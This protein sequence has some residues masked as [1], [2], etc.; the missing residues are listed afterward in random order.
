MLSNVAFKWFRNTKNKFIKNTS[1]VIHNRLYN[2]HKYR[3][4]QN[5]FA[6]KRKIIITLFTYH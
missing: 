4:I 5:V 6:L 3:T 1:L 2:D